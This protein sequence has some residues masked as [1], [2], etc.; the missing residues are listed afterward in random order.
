M[1]R[2]TVGDV[3]ITRV[4]DQSWPGVATSELR[5][6]APAEG[7]APMREG[8]EIYAAAEGG[9]AIGT[10]T[11]GG[12]GPSIE[13]PMAM[14]YLPAGLAEGATVYGDV[15]GKRL[16]LVVESLSLGET[17]LHFGDAARVEVD[18]ERHQRHPLLVDLAR[19]FADLVAVQEQL[20]VA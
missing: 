18:L 11:S 9:A 13:A 4:K 12:F 14:A 6:R 17:Q 5:Y 2:W 8:T 20:A 15:R 3:E 1:N 16:A 19:E 10:V 7:R